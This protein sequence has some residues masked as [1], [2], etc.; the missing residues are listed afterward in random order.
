[1]K[2]SQVL[3]S[4]CSLAFSSPLPVS[5][6]TVGM[7]AFLYRCIHTRLFHTSIS[8]A[9]NIR[10]PLCTHTVGCG[11]TEDSQHWKFQSFKGVCQQ[12]CP[13]FAREEHFTFV[14]LI[15]KQIDLPSALE[16]D[17]L[18]SKAIWYTDIPKQ[19]VWNKISGNAF[20]QQM[21]K[22]RRSLEIC[23]PVVALS[24]LY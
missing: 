1:M 5:Y 16:R 2:S 7:T 14:V 18:S 10:F 13:S 24:T 19:L 9:Q 6:L 4:H 17:T 23:L 21:Q 12:T 20:A 15:R 8:S 3:P 11:T 22:Q